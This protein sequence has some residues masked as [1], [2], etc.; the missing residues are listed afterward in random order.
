MA[1]REGLGFAF[2][3]Q[4]LE[5]LIDMRIASVTIERFR[6][7]HSMTLAF[8][9]LTVL[10]GA[11]GSGKSSVLRAIDWFFKGG[12][13]QPDDICAR[14][15]DAAVSV[16][17]TFSELT[18]AD[19]TALGSYGTEAT[20]TFWRTWSQTAGDKLTGRGLAFPPFEDVRA[21]VG[22]Q[23]QRSAYNELRAARADLGL[24]SITS[25]DK[26]REAMADWERDHHGELKVATSSATHLFGYVGKPRLAGRF[27]YVFVPAVEDAEEQTQDARG[28]L[29]SRLLL[30]S[31][32]DTARIEERLSPLR[33][34]LTA[35][36]SNVLTEEHGAS[37]E[38]LS[39]QVTEALRIYVDEGSVTLG[40]RPPEI[41][42]RPL[43]VDMRVADGGL[44]TDVS[45]QGNGFQ[46]ALLIA[47][48]QVLAKSEEEADPA[49]LFLAIEEPEL[50]QH[51]SQARHLADV[52]SA[53]AS[54]PGSGVQVAYATH[55]PYFIDPSHY[56]RLRRL[57]KR[58]GPCLYPTSEVTAATVAG[59]VARLGGTVDEGQ[60][61]Q[62][63]NITLRR[64][65]S[66][67]V[68]AHAVVLVEGM[69]DAALLAGIADRS[70]G[71]DA[72]GVS[73]VSTNSKT[74][75]PIAW[76]ILSEL[77]IPVFSVFDADAGMAERMTARGKTALDIEHA[78][79]ERN[80]W[81]R[82]ILRLQ[83]AAE[84]DL[85][86]TTVGGTYAVFGD[87]LETEIQRE[88]PTMASLAGTLANEAGDWREKP[89]DWYREAART[90]EGKV[91]DTAAALMAAITALR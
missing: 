80:R 15:E 69:S 1:S 39:N 66:E 3:E 26:A 46:R 5:G 6:C 75:L 53:L 40:M 25:A 11:N 78:L 8:D 23:A 19:R 85:P 79:R 9:P 41:Q 28:T 51:P 7:I 50:Y 55:S 63:M 70:G 24:P 86:I 37:L 59:V 62:R 16:S 30:R 65:L 68:F 77:G 56:E 4:R 12:P 87:C 2:L 34:D 64:L 10:V 35:R 91:P 44:D 72:A 54:L 82:A 42:V 71:F 74:L 38:A 45:R 14:E 89:D 76:A 57:R 61:L 84:V 58:R 33:E 81:N 27:D 90:V 31:T 49:A 29:L 60:V 32:A 43:A 48:L 21:N 36:V 52:L 17:V 88:W 13:L 67:A 22:A 18:L 73:V 20:A 83:G 47:T